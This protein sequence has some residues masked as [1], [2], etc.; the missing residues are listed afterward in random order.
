[1][2]LLVEARPRVLHHL[3][4]VLL[5]LGV[6][7]SSAAAQSRHIELADLGRIVR[8]ADPQL[9]PDGRSI[10]MIVS[11][12]NYAQNRYDAT[13]V[14]VDVASGAQRTVLAGRQG[15]SAPRWSPKGDRIAFLSTVPSTG[16][17][18]ERPA[19][20]LF[21][22][23]PNGDSVTA[24]T[25]AP[26]GV[27]QY[28][29]RPDGG[30]LAYATADEPAPRGADEGEKYNDSFEIGNDDYLVR[31]APTPTHIWIVSATGGD[32]SRLTSGAWSLPSVR[33][34]SS[35]A[36]PI[37]WSPDGRRIAFA[38]VPSPHSGD[39]S[40]STVQVLDVSTH[41]ITAPGG[42]ERT[43]G[44]P[45]FSPDGSQVAYWYS[46]NGDAGYGRDAYVVPVTGGAPRNVT[47]AVDRNMA[48]T[49]WSNDGRSLLVGA[50]DDRRV[51]LWQVPL[52]G[53]TPRKLDLD[54]VSPN[55]SFWVDMSYGSTGAIAFV[56]TTPTR[57]AELYYM[58]DAT[59]KPRRLTDV[60][61]EV[62][63]LTLGR[64]ESVDWTSPDGVKNNG[65][66]TYPAGFDPSKKYPLVLVIHGGP[67]AATLETFS[68]QAQLM[69]ARGWI[70]FQP[71]YRGSDNLGNGYQRLIDNDAGEGPGRDVIAGIA[72]VTKRGFVDTTRV[73]VSGWSYGGFMTSWLIGRYPGRWRAAV[74]GAPVTDWVDQYDLGDAN[75]GR[76]RPF[77]GSPWVGT[78]RVAYEAQSPM[79]Y[80]PQIRTPTLVM[81]NVGDDRVPVSQGYKLWHALKDN[82]VATQFI[83]YPINGHNALDP[84]RARDV[85]RRWIGWLARYLDPAPVSSRSSRH[86][87]A[88][89]N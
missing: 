33:P 1:M 62:A 69:A 46:R 8:V 56:G 25:I 32:A 71:N 5:A 13:L 6:L 81:H 40:R 57:P 4:V 11:R 87:R 78:R 7:A 49:F 31:A 14:V 64:T 15:L 75:V 79:R 30:A 27:Q 83:A 42:G 50:N 52:K 12:A 88:I 59:A 74:S 17:G 44:Y 66:L 36:S 10:A 39:F 16:S 20:Q 9:A 18:A 68:P 23:L 58:S 85:Q 89:G 3:P 43:E 34:P 55:S 35:P 48:R 47:A 29:W 60:N 61:G 63:A 73:A 84:V 21:T 70:V 53:G 37:T 38:K 82:N 65:T 22:V 80:A 41:A 2:P 54:G 19:A 72:A 77:G 76:A 26:H 51:S 24:V 67:R 86:A 28:A 45:S